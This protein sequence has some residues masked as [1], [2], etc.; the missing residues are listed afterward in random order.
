MQRL[1][2]G[3][4]DNSS[5]I[6][7]EETFNPVLSVIPADN[8]QTRNRNRYRYDLRIECIGVYQ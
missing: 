4:V 8:E 1:L 6:A 7:Q 5:T 2:F 3:N